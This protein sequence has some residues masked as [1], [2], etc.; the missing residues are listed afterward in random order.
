MHIHGNPLAIQAANFHSSQLET[1]LEARRAAETRRR[2]RKITENV[3]AASGSE[4]ESM[5]V[6][7]WMGTRAE[8]VRSAPMLA[9]DEYHPS[10][11]G[12]T[13]DEA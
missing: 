2:L 9:G 3:S 1:E 11:R 8:V 4:E 12:N 7:H 13:E 10:H 5:L 6:D